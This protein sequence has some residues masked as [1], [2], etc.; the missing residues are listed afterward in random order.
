MP[1]GLG[2]GLLVDP[3]RRAYRQADTPACGIATEPE[4]GRDN[5]KLWA[6]Y[7]R[8]GFIPAKTLPRLMY[9]PLENLIPELTC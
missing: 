2:A 4:S 8:A 6:W 1:V 5:P 7:E 9:A 3:A